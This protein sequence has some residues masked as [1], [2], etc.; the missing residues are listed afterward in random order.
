MNWIICDLLSLHGETRMS[1]NET[2][3]CGLYLTT[4]SNTD[5]GKLYPLKA[6]KNLPVDR[7]VLE[8]Y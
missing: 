7:T 6:E 5:R 3:P 2:N 4:E 8:I 1:L